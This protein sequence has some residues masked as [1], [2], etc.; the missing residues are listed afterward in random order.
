M[1]G[2][3]GMKLEIKVALVTGAERGDETV[4]ILVKNAGII[5]ILTGTP[6]DATRMKQMPVYHEWRGCLYVI[7]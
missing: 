2:E 4:N 3:T 7:Q 5:D 1:K 6:A